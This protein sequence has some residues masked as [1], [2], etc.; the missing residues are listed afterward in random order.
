MKLKG[1]WDM[2]GNSVTIF[3]W[4]NL[5]ERV[6]MEDIGMDGMIK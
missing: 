3:L 1:T 4:E 6:H 5:I 2:F